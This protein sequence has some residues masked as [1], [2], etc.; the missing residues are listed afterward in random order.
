MCDTALK[1]G[2]KG[3]ENVSKTALKR[4]GRGGFSAASRKPFRARCR[5]P[6]ETGGKGLVNTQS[7]GFGILCLEKPIIAACDDLKLLP[8]DF[9]VKELKA[10]GLHQKIS[11]PLTAAWPGSRG[12][13]G[14]AA[15]K[16]A[17]GGFQKCSAHKA[18]N[19]NE[20]RNQQKS[21]CARRK[22]P[23][24]TPFCQSIVKIDTV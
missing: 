18:Q 23:E 5:K 10:S 9:S 2:P 12:N 11:A 15:G 14:E 17:G 3:L 22:P 8:G 4:S 7:G 19:Q 24:R 1:S 13:G 6:L 16:Q 21:K 20:R